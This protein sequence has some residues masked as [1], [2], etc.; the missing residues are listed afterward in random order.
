MAYRVLLTVQPA[1]W[2]T[3][4]QIRHHASKCSFQKSKYAILQQVIALSASK[5]ALTAL[6]KQ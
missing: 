5:T 6:V 4:H 2:T 1:A 3:T